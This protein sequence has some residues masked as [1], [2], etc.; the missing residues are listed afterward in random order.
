MSFGRPSH[1]PQCDYALDGLPAAGICPECGRAYDGEFKILRGY[2]AGWGSNAASSRSW[3]PTLWLAAALIVMVLLVDPRTRSRG[4]KLLDLFVLASLAIA[5]GRA[6]IGR[7]T[8]DGAPCQLWLS[9]SGYWLRDRTIPARDGR[10]ERILRGIAALLTILILGAA[11]YESTAPAI[12]FLGS[13]LVFGIV[14]WTS[15][16]VKA[17]VTNRSLGEIG[18]AG[19]TSWE[20]SLRVTLTPQRGGLTRIRIAP[21]PRPAHELDLRQPLQFDA[22][23][24]AEEATDLEREIRGW[25]SDS[26]PDSQGSTSRLSGAT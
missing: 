20:P 6:L 24:T 13:L 26:V 16:R 10:F 23:L 3:G 21:C 9:P 5:F 2:S 15:V 14:Y 17:R 18:T 25:V 22:L 1:C 11:F 7:L 8:V 4:I 19:F 12:V